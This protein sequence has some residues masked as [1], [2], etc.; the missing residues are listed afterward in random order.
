MHVSVVLLCAIIWTAAATLTRLFVEAADLEHAEAA[1]LMWPFFWT[2]VVISWA[3]V[4]AWVLATGEW[5][6]PGWW[7][8]W[9][10]WR[11]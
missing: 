1:A 8:K 11:P 2:F 9:M 6:Q 3:V 10:A 4:L 7:K 5:T